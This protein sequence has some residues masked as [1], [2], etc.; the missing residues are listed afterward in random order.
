LIANILGHKWADQQITS[1]YNRWE[2][3]P[4]MRQA[5]ERWA[6]RLEQIATDEPAKVVKMR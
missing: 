3:L 6:S 2:K 5:L 4:E 1:V